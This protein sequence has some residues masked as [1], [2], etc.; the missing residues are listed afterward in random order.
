MAMSTV[1]AAPVLTQA[2]VHS[3]VIQ[4]LIDESIAG[5]SQHRHPDRLA[6]SADSTR[7][8]RPHGRMD[9]RRRRDERPD[10]VLDELTVTPRSWPASSWSQTSS[11]TIQVRLR[12]A[13]SVRDSSGIYVA[14]STARILARVWR[15]VRLAWAH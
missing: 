7:D 2:Q 11:P 6:R 13:W 14:R 5:E 8:R 4:P 15:T 3:L 1:G 9:R 10:A 12:W